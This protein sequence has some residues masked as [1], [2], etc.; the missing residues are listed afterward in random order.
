M[1][2]C[3]RHRWR[4]EEQS[5]ACVTACGGDHVTVSRACWMVGCDPEVVACNRR[6]ECCTS[7][8]PCSRT[9]NRDPREGCSNRGARWSVSCDRTVDCKVHST[10]DC[11]CTRSQSH[12]RSV[13]RGT[14]DGY[15]R[16]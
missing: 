1:C 7:C 12:S 16:R 6:S 9:A 2:D 13:S 10:K 3:C 8:C 15:V 5:P 14:A 11:C 4:Y